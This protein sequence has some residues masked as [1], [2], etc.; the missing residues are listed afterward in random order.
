VV[1]HLI[2]PLLA[3]VV[4]LLGA[5][6]TRAAG[7]HAHLERAAVAAAREVRVDSALVRA[8]TEHESHWRPGVVNARGCVGLMQVCPATLPSCQADPSGVDCLH[9]LGALLDPV[10]NLHVGARRLAEWRETCR[11][12]TGHASEKHMLAG[13]SGAD[14]VDHTTCGQRRDRRGR[15]RDARVHKVVIE[16]MKIAARIRRRHLTR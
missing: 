8:I 7:G 12:L 13:F 3:A 5:Y 16:I 4:V 6:P 10:H 1:T 14:A 11:R 9:E 2:P 15:W